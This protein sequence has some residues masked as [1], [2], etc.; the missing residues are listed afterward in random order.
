MNAAELIICASG[1]VAL[2]ATCLLTPMIICYKT[3]WSTYHLGKLLAKINYAGLPN[4]ISGREI[5][6][7]L[8]Q[9]QVTGVALAK[10][11]LHILENPS[12]HQRIIKDLQQVRQ[13]LG[14]SGAVE[15]VADLII[16]EKKKK[17]GG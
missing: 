11:A 12:E 16:Q 7:E 5:V 9:K 10:A 8:L 3:S 17:K 15:R 4:I 14:A 1:T 2:E 6:P 13:T